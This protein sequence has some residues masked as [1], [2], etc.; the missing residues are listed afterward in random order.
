M[1]DRIYHASEA[2]EE[3]YVWLCGRIGQPPDAPRSTSIQ[4]ALR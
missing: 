3:V 4:L 2:I 1:V